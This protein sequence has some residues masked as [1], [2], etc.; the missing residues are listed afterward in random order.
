MGPFY[1]RDAQALKLKGQTSTSFLCLCVYSTTPAPRQWT[2]TAQLAEWGKGQG[3]R[4]KMRNKKL[5]QKYYSTP[6]VTKQLQLDVKNRRTK[7]REL[8]GYKWR[9]DHPVGFGE[10]MKKNFGEKSTPGQGLQLSE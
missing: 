1:F 6:Q 5:I 2:K 3:I 9:P 7:H 8:H 10:D 4:V